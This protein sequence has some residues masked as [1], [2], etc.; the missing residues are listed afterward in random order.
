MEYMVVP[1]MEILNPIKP[2]DVRGTLT[3]YKRAKN[4]AIVAAETVTPSQILRSSP[5]DM[6]MIPTAVMTTE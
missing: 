1:K 5:C 6:A 4:D 3:R 2:G